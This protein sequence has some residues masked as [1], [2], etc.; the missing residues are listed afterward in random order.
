MPLRIL[1][2]IQTVN[3]IGGGPI[4]GIRQI[5][6][7]HRS[8]GHTLEIACCDP[9]SA[10]FLSFPAV[11]VHPQG[12]L[13]IDRFF[14]LSLLRWLKRHHRDYDGV[15]VNGIWGFHLL[16]A[17][18]ALKGSATPLLVFTHGMLDPWFRWRYPLK[19]LKKWLVWPWA[20]HPPLHHAAAVCFT[21][22][23][24]KLLARQS[25]WLYSVN[26]AVV[27]YGTQ[28]IPDPG[29]D[30][31][32]AFLQQHPPL[33]GRQRLLFLGRV[34]PK[35]APDLLLHAIAALQREGIWDPAAMVLVLAGPA[36][37]A[38]ASKLI[39]LAEQLGITSSLHWTGMLQGDQKWGAFQA[40]DAFVLPS[41]QENFGIAVAEAL[42]CSTPALLCRPVNIAPDVAADHAGLVEPDTRSGVAR[43]LRRW[44]ALPADER[45][46]M[47]HHA[48]ACFESRYRIRNASISITRLLHTAILERK[49]AASSPQRRI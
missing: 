27:N 37:G 14:P 6:A 3:P 41:H 15:V 42:S 26:E 43:L 25:F 44:L 2:V 31:A 49:L 9:A 7:A 1:H 38:Y 47:R 45:I 34:A 35:K 40:A 16:A 11:P 4:E 8:F 48:R 19:H 10:P 13:W 22:E 18:L 32:T 20:I 33:A 24:E 36:Q 39:R 12:H 5:A 17:H 21:C 46:A 23:Q 29:R 28:G 30:Y